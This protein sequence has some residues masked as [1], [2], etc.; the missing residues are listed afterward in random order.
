[1]LG[2]LVEEA[3]GVNRKE[4]KVTCKTIAQ[5]KHYTCIG[6]GISKK[7]YGGKYE[8]LTGTGQGNILSGAVCR[9]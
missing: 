2:G 7:V 6:C 1:M 4:T 9:D 8:K 3:L 5:F